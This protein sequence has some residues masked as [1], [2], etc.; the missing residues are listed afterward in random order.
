[1]DLDVRCEFDHRWQA[2]QYCHVLSLRK[3]DDDNTRG[4][5]IA[6][7]VQCQFDHRRQAHINVVTFRNIL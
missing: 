6:V 7:D 2:Y 3:A 1:M 5:F 4:F